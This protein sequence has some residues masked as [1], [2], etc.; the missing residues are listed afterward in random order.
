MT[1]IRKSWKDNHHKGGNTDSPNKVFTVQLFCHT[2][3]PNKQPF[4]ACDHGHIH[5][6]EFTHT[7]NYYSR[8]D[9]Y[10]F[11]WA[12]DAATINF[13][14][15]YYS[16]CGFYLNIYSTH[17]FSITTCYAYYHILPKI[18][19]IPSLTSKVLTQVFLPHSK[20]MPPS[21]KKFIISKM[22]TWQ[23]DK[24]TVIGSLNSLSPS[25]VSSSC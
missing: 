22:N 3:A 24:N 17:R 15:S 25:F 4:T 9:Y 11:C 19:P 12:P 20:S 16:G 1:W 23:I 18:S 2:S 6:I 14:G 13:E 5:L 8:A 10:F 21:S 7:C